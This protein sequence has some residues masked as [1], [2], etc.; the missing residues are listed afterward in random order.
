MKINRRLKNFTTV[1]VTSTLLL[2]GCGARTGTL[3][4][5]TAKATTSTS[6]VD[7]DNE[8]IES[9]F[10]STPDVADTQDGFANVSPAVSPEVSDA[11]QFDVRRWSDSSG[12]FTVDAAFVAYED[13]SVKMRRVN[14]SELSVAFSR[15][16]ET[17]KAYVREVTKLRIPNVLHAHVI[18]VL[19]GNRISVKDESAEVETIVLDGVYQSDSDARKQLIPLVFNKKV[20]VLW[21]ERDNNGWIVGDVYVAGKKVAVSAMSASPDE[22]ESVGRDRIQAP[23]MRMSPVATPS[24]SSGRTWIESYTRKDGTRVKGHWRENPSK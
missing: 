1:L 14:G 15:L 3:D 13:P 12:A 2:A 5:P 6:E 20:E 17:D 18:A 11:R 22:P 9:G 4:E 24:S 19:A 7:S 10:T 21:L 8:S 16:S 23:V